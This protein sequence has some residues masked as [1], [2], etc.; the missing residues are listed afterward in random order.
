MVTQLITIPAN[1][2][3]G[4]RDKEIDE[5]DNSSYPQVLG[6]FFNTRNNGGDANF[7]IGIKL[8]QTILVNPHHNANWQAGSAAKPADRMIPLKLNIKGNKLYASIQNH[9]Q[10]AAD[11]ELEISVLVDE[12]TE[13]CR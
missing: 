4:I 5:L 8:G 10:L 12:E 9:V 1:S 7:G 3:P 6:A 11:L 13:N 2:Q